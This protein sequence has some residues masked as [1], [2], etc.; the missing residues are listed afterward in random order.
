MSAAHR[1][2]PTVV[3]VLVSVVLAALVGPSAAPAQSP[4]PSVRLV[5]P[6]GEL[7]LR[8]F[9]GRCG[10]TLEPGSRRQAVTSSSAWHGRTTTLP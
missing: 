2:R 1:H 5:G 3:L 10:S 8:R 4:V 7:T 9:N 6:A